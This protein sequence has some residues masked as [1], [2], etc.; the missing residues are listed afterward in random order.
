[1]QFGGV[2]ITG[3]DLTRTLIERGPAGTLSSRPRMPRSSDLLSTVTLE[4]AYRDAVHS[5]LIRD[6]CSTQL[7]AVAALTSIRPTAQCC[8]H[9]W[10]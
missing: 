1:M 2:A 8:R 6:E 5:K 9:R 4:V 3:G 10:T 7:F